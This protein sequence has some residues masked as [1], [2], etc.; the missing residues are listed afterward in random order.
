MG[1]VDVVSVLSEM[2]TLLKLKKG[3]VPRPA[4]VADCF[5]AR[6]E[7][8][9]LK[10]GQRSAIV[11]EG[12]EVNWSEFNAL[13]NRYAHY[14]KSQGVQRGDTVS[15]IMEN[16]IEFLALLVGV[17]KIGVTAGL[18]NTNLTGKPLV[19]CITVTHSKKCIFGSEVSGALNEVKDELGLTEGEDYFEMPDGGLDATTNWAKNLAEGAAAA[20]SENPEETSLITLG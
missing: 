19:H 8:N 12:Q 18:I 17:N 7:A 20:S 5:G 15:V 14:L 11:F 13:A 1:I 10:F 2:P 6:V 9:A 4:S 3:M 16:R